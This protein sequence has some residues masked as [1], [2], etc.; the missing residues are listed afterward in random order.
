MSNTLTPQ[1]PPQPQS[2]FD[3]IWIEVNAIITAKDKRYSATRFGSLLGL[4]VVLVVTNGYYSAQTI[5]WW[6]NPLTDHV[7]GL[8]LQVAWLTNAGAMVLLLAMLGVQVHNRLGG[9]LIDQRNLMSLSR[10]QLVSWTVLVTSA[11]LTIALVRSFTADIEDPLAIDI[12]TEVWQ[13]LGISV[14]STVGRGLVHANKKTKLVPN[15]DV[16]ANQAADALN[17]RV[18]EDSP[19]R[20][21]PAEIEEEREGSIY[22]NP[23]PKFAGITDLF[24][25]DE[26]GNTGYVDISKVQMFFF[27]IAALIAYGTS[28]Y[29][30]LGTSP[31]NLASLP[32]IT[33]GLVTILGISHAAYIGNKAL[34]HTSTTPSN[35]AQAA[36]SGDLEQ[37]I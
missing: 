25:G 21:T 34:D 26:V 18:A 5:Q 10:F 20:T 2:L 29:N 8:P 19:D 24:E 22:R 16:V 15:S 31:Q 27:T 32:E 7:R 13:L 35:T 23:H 17:A 6:D 30:V 28:I 1:P 36:A 33:P 9:A 14:A 37:D 12:P 3:R 4:L 11:F